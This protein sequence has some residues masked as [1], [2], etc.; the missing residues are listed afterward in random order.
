M[1]PKHARRIIIDPVLL[2]LK[3][4]RVIIALVSLAVSALI[5]SVPQLAP[6]HGELLFVLVSLALALIG[7]LSI[8]DAMTAARDVPLS[9]AMRDHIRQVINALIEE[10]LADAE[11]A[12]RQSREI[13]SRRPDNLSH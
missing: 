13:E 9:D 10:A 3:S 12:L 7:G 8:E 4:R 11:A 5:M 6:L 1:T 2:I